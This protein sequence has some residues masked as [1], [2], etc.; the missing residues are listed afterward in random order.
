M[1]QGESGVLFRR[2]SFKLD[3]GRFLRPVHGFKLYPLAPFD[4][5]EFTAPFTFK[6]DV[7]IRNLL[8]RSWWSN[9]SLLEHGDSFL[10]EY[11][12]TLLRDGESCDRRY[13][14]ACRFR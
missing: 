13:R 11:K 8:A 10:P 6:R 1:A 7:P 14:R 3:D 12:W 4:S 2:A 9:E 5:T